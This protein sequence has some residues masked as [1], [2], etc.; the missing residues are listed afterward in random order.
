MDEN[1]ESGAVT[2][3]SFSIKGNRNDWNLPEAIQRGCLDES[4]PSP[5]DM[6]Q[7]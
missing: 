4:A 7:Q 3:K 5:Y 6:R 1:R 2:V